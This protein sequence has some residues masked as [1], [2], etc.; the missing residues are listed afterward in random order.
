MRNAAPAHPATVCDGGSAA[1]ATPAALAAADAHRWRR[2]DL[3]RARSGPPP[4]G[5][6]PGCRPGGNWWASPCAPAPHRQT[7]PCQRS[8]RLHAHPATGAAPRRSTPPPYPAATHGA[9]RRRCAPRARW[10]QGCDRFPGRSPPPAHEGRPPHGRSRRRPPCGCRNRGRSIPRAAAAATPRRRDRVAA[11]AATPAPPSAIPTTPDPPKWPPRT[12]DDSVP[13]RYPP[14]AA[15]SVRHA[16]RRDQRPAA[17]NRRGPDAASRWGW[18]QSAKRSRRLPAIRVALLERRVVGA[19]LK[20][21]GAQGVEHMRRRFG[22]DGD[23]RLVG[24]QRQA[25]G[26]RQQMQRRAGMGIVCF[27]RAILRIAHQRTADVGAVYTNLMGA[28]GFG[29]QLQPTDPRRL[30]HHPVE[31]ARALALGGIHLH[32]PALL[33]R[34]AALGQ[35]RVNHAGW[36]RRRAMN[37]RPIALLH[38]PFAE[39]LAEFTQSLGVPA[40]NQ[41]AG[42]VAVQAMRQLRL[43]AQPKAQII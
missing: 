38:P 43:G 1:S 24:R 3:R 22:D 5:R 10:R 20:A 16:R 34:A 39:Q 14:V 19:R 4:A 17:P 13:G 12:R 28:A 21:A 40:Q 27:R 33:P 18:G 29:R 26:A 8:P 42:G 32:P 11:T 25:D 23:G 35:R 41:A 30:P 6:H 7:P 31:G 37:H 15:Q 9:V 2:T 36:R